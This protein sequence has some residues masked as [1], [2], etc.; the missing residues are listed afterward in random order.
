MRRLRLF[1]RDHRILDGHA[2]VPAGQSLA[3]YLAHRSRYVNLTSVDWLGTGERIPHMALKVD[4]VLWAAAPA[5]EL[6]LTGGMGPG[7][8]RP[9][10]VEL[11]GGYLLAGGLLIMEN[12]RLSDYL[13]SAPPFIPLRD[14]HLRPRG[15]AL[16]DIVVNQ[17]AIQV[18]R[19]VAAGDGGAPSPGEVP[20]PGP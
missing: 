12:Q 11:E 2:R 20:A 19:E 7:M 15:K 18:V 13:H 1:L 14:A 17:G 10:E 6:P 16:G 5:G 9:V 4:G 3:T 8:T